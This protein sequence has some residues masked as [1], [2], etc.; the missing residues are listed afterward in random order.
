MEYF[1]MIALIIVFA[2]GYIIVVGKMAD[3]DDRDN[4]K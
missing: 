4:K 2:T 1:A 3:R